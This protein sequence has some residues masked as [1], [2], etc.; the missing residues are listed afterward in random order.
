[1]P[2]RENVYNLKKIFKG[3][4][5]GKKYQVVLLYHGKKYQI[6]LLSHEIFFSIPN[7]LALAA[8]VL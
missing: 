3:K 1:M 5:Y 8:T 7:F 6:V 2:L 4:C